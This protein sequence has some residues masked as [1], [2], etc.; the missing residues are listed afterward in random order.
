MHC[1]TIATWTQ[2][3][4]LAVSLE[5]NIK[6]VTGYR[7]VTRSHFA[8]VTP[9]RRGYQRRAKLLVSLSPRIPEGKR[10]LD[11]PKG[12]DGTCNEQF[13]N[14]SQRKLHSYLGKARRCCHDKRP[15]RGCANTLPDKKM[16]IR[17]FVVQETAM[18][19]LTL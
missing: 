6:L 4:Y 11:S 15:L 13:G 18:A 9:S 5:F 8:E 7:G 14:T 2:T 12:G 19:E 10:R 1:I 16:E 17:G 3:N